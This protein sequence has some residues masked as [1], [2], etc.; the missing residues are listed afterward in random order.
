MENN[1][2]LATPVCDDETQLLNDELVVTYLQD[3]PDFFLRNPQLV[4]SIKFADTQRGVISLVE[5]QQQVQRQKIHLLEEEITQLLSV[6]NV[7]ERLFAIY[8]DLYLQL[9]ASQNLTEFFDC[10]AQTTTQLLNLSAVKLYLVEKPLAIEHPVLVNDNCQD[11]LS[12]RLADSDYYFGRIQ[13]QERQQVFADVAV[14]SVVMI[15]LSEADKTRG[16][17]AFSSVD[18][19]HFNPAMDTLLLNQFRTLVAKLL[20]QQLAK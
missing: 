4:S 5:R 2:N 3:N 17:I 15:K 7:N 19:D 13:Q 9:I 14:G 16:F 18:A 1:N 11:L 10:L 12:K 8:N 6:A 20:V